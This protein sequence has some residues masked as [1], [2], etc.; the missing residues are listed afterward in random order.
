M[1]DKLRS[2]LYVTF[3][4]VFTAWN[5]DIFVTLFFV[6]N[7]TIVSQYGVIKSVYI[8]DVMM[9]NKDWVT[10]ITWSNNSWYLVA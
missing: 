2:P 8:H 1:K 3:I 7:E 4:L 10:E 5:W 6:S 9:W